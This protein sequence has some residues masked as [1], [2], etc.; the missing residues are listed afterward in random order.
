[1]PDPGL[2]DVVVCRLVP[3]AASRPVSLASA[4]DDVRIERLHGG[5]VE[6]KPLDG[7]RSHA[8]YEHVSAG[9]KT[10]QCLSANFLLQVE[11]DAALVAVQVKERPGHPRVAQG[12]VV[13]GGVASSVLD[14]DHV[15]AEV[16]ENVGRQRPHH[17]PGQV[18]H[19]DTGERACWSGHA[20]GAEKSAAPSRSVSSGHRDSPPR[21][22]MKRPTARCQ[23]GSEPN[24]SRQDQR[25]RVE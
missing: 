1:M 22:Q 2:D 20:V 9:Y 5:V 25:C 11:L 14:F 16:R 10:P 13:P 23:N 8:V 18:Q 19:P 21:R 3:V 7:F 17:D 4:V 24:S 6:A 15:S 12:P